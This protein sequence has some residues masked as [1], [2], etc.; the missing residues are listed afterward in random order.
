MRAKEELEVKQA[1]AG[2]AWFAPGPGFGL[3]RQPGGAYPIC[4]TSGTVQVLV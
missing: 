1:E 2:H 3:T 4:S